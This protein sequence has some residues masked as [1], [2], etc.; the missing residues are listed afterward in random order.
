MV[1]VENAVASAVNA[2]VFS[3]IAARVGNSDIVQFQVGGVPGFPLLECLVDGELIIF[4]D[5]PVQ[6]FN[7]VIVSHE[8]NRL[9]AQFQNGMY[10]EVRLENGFISTLLV[11]LPRSFMNQ[12]T[13]LMGNYNGDTS[14][15]L[16]PRN[17]Q[18]L[19]PLD[20]SMMDIH[21]RFGITCELIK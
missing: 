17:S 19:L 1:Q 13:G 15:D 2:T 3:A 4:D 5:V 16:S 21:E 18:E 7:N 14:D 10:V 20:S 12:I 9:N 8:D 6:D 11:S